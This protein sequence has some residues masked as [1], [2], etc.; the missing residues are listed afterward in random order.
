MIPLFR[1]LTSL[2]RGPTAYGTAPHKP[3]LLLAVIDGF[4]QG[5][6]YGR[7]VYINGDLLTRFHDYWAALVKTNNKPNFS[8]PFYHL[9]NEP[10]GFWQLQCYPGKTVPVT[11]SHSIKSFKA[12]TE[13]IRCAVLSIELYKA[14]MNPVTRE[15][16]S[17]A[18]LEKYF[19]DEAQHLTDND[20]RYS[21]LIREEILYEPGVNYARKVMKHFEELK[22]E[23]RE[24]ELTMRSDIFRKAVLE[25]YDNRCTVSGLKIKAPFRVA[26]V[27][28][29]HIAPF[30]ESYD[31]TIT[32]GVA[33][34]P[35]LHRAFDRGLIAFSDDYQILVH[36]GIK[37]YSLETGLKQLAGQK[38]ILPIDSRFHPSLEK[39]EQHRKRFAF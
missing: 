6:L 34:A 36:P 31:D 11:R 1:Q 38:L 19:P 22:Q 14:L 33:M 15:D 8:L 29:C 28:A 26:M 17:R 30:A 20:K 16:L 23:E 25:Q 18:I 13:T 12:L 35:T 2:R 24:E 10:S 9:A 21:A 27:D 3:I 37:D 39:L 32:N 5:E 7:E 4:R